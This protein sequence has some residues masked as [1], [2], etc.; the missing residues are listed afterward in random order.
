MS[1]RTLPVLLPSAIALALRVAPVAL[2]GWAIA[3]PAVS[4]AAAENIQTAAEKAY[5]ISAGPLGVALSEFAS[6]AGVTIQID[7]RLVDGLNTNGIRGTF[8]I[9][10]GFVALLAGTPLEIVE[11]KPGVF[12]IRGRQD[13]AVNADATVL[14]EVQV[15]A[16]RDDRT[17]EGTKSYTTGSLTIGKGEQSIRETPNS[18]SVVTRQRIEDQNFVTLEDAMQYVTA[19]K[20]T[21]YGTTS[22]AIEAR[23]YT[24]DHYMLDGVSTSSRVYENNFGLVM[25][26]RIEIWRGS[27]GLLQGSGDPGGTVN[28]VRKRAQKDFSLNASALA[29]SWDRYEGDFDITGSLAQDGRLRGRFVGAYQDRG[30]FT[31][32]EWSRTPLFYGTLEY[33]LTPNTTLSVGDSWQRRKARPFYGIAAYD[34]GTYPDISRSTYLGADWA[35]AFQRVNRS[36][37]ELEHR[38]SGGGAAKLT[39]SYEDR[40]N[41]SEIVWG[42]TFVDR[43]TGDVHMLPFFSWGRERETN[44][45][46]QV[47]KPLQWNGL[48]QEFLLGASYQKY[49]NTSAYNSNTYGQNGFDQNIFDPDIHVPKPNIAI[50]AP[51]HSAQIQSGVYGQ[52]RLKPVAGLTLIGGGRLAWFRS[53]DLDDHTNDKSVPAEFIPYAGAIVDVS[54]DFSL[55]ASYSS[56]FNPQSD[57]DASG[58]YLPPRKGNQV[59][60]GVKGE[61][62]DGRLNSS[63]AIYRIEDVNRAIP[64]P[65]VPNAS[66]AAGKVR[67]QGAE[68][69]L[70]GAILPHWNLTTGYGYNQTKQVRSSPGQQGL[71]FTT[72]FPR[73]T[74]SL[75]SDWQFV[76]GLANGFGVGAG[77]RY[78]SR[79]Y[80][81]S[82][83]FNWAQGGFTVWSAQASYRFNSHWKTSLTMNNLFDKH[84]LDR[85]ESDSRQTYF[86]DP[87]NYMLSLRYL[88]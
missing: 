64:D 13:A 81:T 7:S 58:R 21:N 49:K 10:E 62:L 84:Y 35:N 75:W 6:E 53:E 3:V 50:D 59:E 23:G 16:K 19:M 60:T 12:F 33:D 40:Y 69:E 57:T 22:S 27:S 34:D 72:T 26:D 44:I 51:S 76:E 68:A 85:P 39:T 79:I 78:R 17:T 73:H 38:L 65:G 41:H 54:S 8:K 82:S 52:A 74:L 47:T 70:S 14:P 67:S 56:I 87:A 37:A 20:V 29:G 48:K 55:Y 32:Y 43:T 45:D 86:G 28:L 18:V 36:F 83:G 71:P 4:V 66:V 2:G 42:D 80:N 46:A 15:T 9:N 63:I 1:S 77:V 24:I 88:W 11:S 30:N 61:H 25:Y 5:T 31:D